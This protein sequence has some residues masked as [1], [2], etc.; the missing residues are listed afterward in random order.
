MDNHYLNT[1]PYYL[2][3]A[4]F[5]IKFHLPNE[6]IFKI[7]YYY[8]GLFHPI[9]NHL[10]LRT[11][12]FIQIVNNKEQVKE[13]EMCLFNKHIHPD[14]DISIAPYYKNIMIDPI[15]EYYFNSSYDRIKHSVIN[16]CNNQ[17]F[18]PTLFKFDDN[19]ENIIYTTINYVKTTK[20]ISHLYNP[21][22]RENDYNYCPRF[23]EKHLKQI[24]YC[25]KEPEREFGKIFYNFDNING[26][27]SYYDN[28]NILSLWNLG[29]NYRNKILKPLFYYKNDDCILTLYSDMI[30]NIIHVLCDEPKSL[31][32][33]V[34]YIY[35]NDY[36]SFTEYY[37]LKY[38][39]Y[40]VN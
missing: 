33:P 1:H 11:K 2:L 4:I 25:R 30:D 27:Q 31:K 36:I 12:P 26:T 10:Y 14:T 23:Y 32:E 37:N 38:F 7:I 18:K 28:I 8:R 20:D 9:I 24:I 29:V 3:F 16:N 15:E 34:K 5:G 21:K 39:D 19:N 35:T 40:Y 22:K 6:L 13:Y 17:V